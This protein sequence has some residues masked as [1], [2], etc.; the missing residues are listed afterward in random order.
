MS[1]THPASSKA[2]VNLISRNVKISYDSLI[3]DNEY[4]V[5]E[6]YNGNNEICGGEIM[7]IS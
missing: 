3:G 6:S 2:D 1:L 4:Q 7:K 5:I